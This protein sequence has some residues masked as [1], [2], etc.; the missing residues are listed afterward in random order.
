[1]E[2]R[3][4]TEGILSPKQAHSLVSK[5]IYSVEGIT[6]CYLDTVTQEVVVGLTVESDR[7][8]LDKTVSL[9]MQKEKNHRVLSNR[10]YIEN[11]TGQ[12]SS[13]P[14]FEVDTVYENDGSVRRDIA[15]LLI[16]HL[17][18][19]FVKHTGH[20]HPELRSYPSLIPLNSLEK[21]S[22]IP[23]FPQNIHLVSEFPHQMEALE[24]VK[25][26]SDLQ[27]N[28]RLSPYALSPAVCFHCYEE[29]S[30]RRLS[31]P[32]L[33]TA[34]GL[35]FRHEAAWRL[36]KHRLNE[37]S[38]R[39]VVIF[40]SGEYVESIRMKLMN[41]VWNLFVDLG[42]TGKIE[43]ASDPF[44]FSEDA[45]KSQHQLMANTK[46]ELVVALGDEN[47][48]IASFNHVGD[49]LCKPFD[50]C[51]S[52]NKPLNSG[53]VAFGIDRWAY[54]LLKTYGTDLE[55]WPGRIRTMLSV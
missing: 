35:C 40:G 9:M 38:M 21:C 23:Y 13:N 37:F 10:V 54:A 49:S 42:L 19:L 39:E 44:Y 26:T 5:L 4:A 12:T 31:E 11:L 25:E 53:C 47:F 14:L 46:Y 24:R 50:V 29:L 33:L 1:M 2:K 43:T 28:A 22:Y 32:V 34:R 18:A 6:N 27:G 30:G 17:D 8:S 41:D 51:D 55:L 45:A 48:S 15:V 20:A 16:D 52:G 36:G 7:V 3:Y